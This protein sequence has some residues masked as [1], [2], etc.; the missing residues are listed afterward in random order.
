MFAE[1]EKLLLG[2]IIDPSGSCIDQVLD[3]LP[4]GLVFPDE[5]ELAEDVRLRLYDR[6]DISGKGFFSVDKEFDPITFGDRERCQAPESSAGRGVVG[7]VF[8]EFVCHQ[9][10]QNFHL[11]FVFAPS[12]RTRRRRTIAA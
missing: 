9:V 2:L 1:P 5:I 4:S 11:V 7:T 12:F 6:L 3:K 8:L 10:G